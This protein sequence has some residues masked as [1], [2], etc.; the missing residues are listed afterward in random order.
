MHSHA[1]L[2]FTMHAH[3]PGLGAGVWTSELVFAS[4]SYN[5]IEF[6]PAIT[7]EEAD[8]RCAQCVCVCMCIGVC[9]LVCACMSV[10]KHA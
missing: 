4:S 1:L 7:D 6:R 8:K 3:S 2:L 10:C 5:N 9:T